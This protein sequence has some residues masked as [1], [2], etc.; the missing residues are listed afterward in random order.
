MLGHL[1]HTIFCLLHREI[2][3]VK[4][5]GRCLFSIFN[6]TIPSLLMDFAM[7]SGTNLDEALSQ[8][9][10]IKWHRGLHRPCCQTAYHKTKHTGILSKTAWTES[11]AKKNDAYCGSWWDWV[12]IL[13]IWY[14]SAG[15]KLLYLSWEWSFLAVSSHRC[16]L[17]M[18]FQNFNLFKGINS[19]WLWHPH[20]APGY[21]FC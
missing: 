10:W 19:L 2:E 5:K 20:M 12:L 4:C 8:T 6:E 18:C 21:L 13:R 11:R 3:G 15:V 7:G 9:Q 16:L 1:W 14:S 17:A